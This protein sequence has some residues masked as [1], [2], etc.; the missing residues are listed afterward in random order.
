MGAVKGQLVILTHFLEGEN[1]SWEYGVVENVYDGHV[2][3]AKEFGGRYMYVAT[4]DDT[5]DEYDSL[6]GKQKSRTFVT[7]L[8]SN[9]RPVIAKNNIF[10]KYKFEPE[11]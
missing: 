2:H 5:D 4:S 8:T 1:A 7:P 10:G 9:G 11:N 6:L 3:V